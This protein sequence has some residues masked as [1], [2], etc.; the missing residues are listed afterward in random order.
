MNVCFIRIDLGKT[1]F[2][3]VGMDDHGN[4]VL[5]ERFSG[6]PSMNLLVNVPPCLIGIEASGAATKSNCID[7]L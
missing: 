3:L 4:V 1:A 6:R 5:S 7:G 2:H